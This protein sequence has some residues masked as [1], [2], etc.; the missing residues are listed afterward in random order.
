MADVDVGPFGEHDGTEEPT[1]ENIPL[2]LV[3]PGRSTWDPRGSQALQAHG[4]QHV[5]RKHH[6]EEN[7]LK[8][9][10]MK[11]WKVLLKVCIKA[12]LEAIM[13]PWEQS[14][15]IISTSEMDSYTTRIM[16]IPSQPKNGS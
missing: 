2:D 7:L 1:D 8:L 11:P 9:L 10:N 16:S 15:F 6:L 13:N 5:N 14:V 12:Y 4:N 3:T